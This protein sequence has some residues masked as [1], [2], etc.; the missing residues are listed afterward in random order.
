MIPNRFHFVFGLQR[1]RNPFHLVY[2]LC[3]ESCLRVNNP[4][5][6]YFYYHY[7]PYGRYWDLL[8]DKVVPV[9]VDLKDFV[10]RYDYKDRFVRR[11]D[12]AH[13]S[14]FIRLEKLIAHGGVYA[15]I[16]TIFVSKI[17]ERLFAKQF[18]L[19]R[20]DDVVSWET[21]VARPSLCNAF[22]MAEKEAAFGVRWLGEMESAFDGSWSNHSTLL[23]RELSERYPELIHIEP[24]G[25]FYK[26]MWTREGI[27]TLLEGCDP[28]FTG[29]VSMH[30]WS[31]LWWSKERR[32]F[33]DFH[34]GLITERDVR[35][36]DSTYNLAAR[37]FLPPPSAVSLKGFARRLFHASRW[38]A[39]RLPG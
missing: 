27:R 30:L 22:I 9:R 28:D 13:Q 16:D 38:A 4:E 23:P 35:E 18:V 25:T 3:I 29:V 11:Y 39:G 32:D 17:P 15:D 14:D 5:R 20:E 6:I 31:H 10:R 26:H 33:S 36:K 7:E 1:Q 21:G 37:R 12:Y 8:K 24:S 19:G 34:S 2:Y